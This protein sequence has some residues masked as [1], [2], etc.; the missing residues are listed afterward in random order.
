MPYATDNAVPDYVPKKHRAQ[1]RHV[2]NSTYDRAKEEGKDDKEAETLAFRE[3]NAV[4][5]PN[6]S[7]KFMKLLD[8]S[9][10]DFANAFADQVIHEIEKYWETLPVEV[11]PA[12]EGAILSGIGKGMLE[13]D[14]GDPQLLARAKDLAEQYATSRSAELVGWTRDANGNLIPNPDARWAI[15]TTTRERIREIIQNAFTEDL[16]I[17]EVRDQIQL[18]LATQIEGNGIFSMGRAAIIARTE[19][20]N[21]QS[22][23]NFVAWRESGMVQKIRWLTAEDE[24]VCDVCE[25]NDNSVV[26]IGQP[27]PTGDL[28]PG[29]HP[30]CRCAIV[31]E[32]SQMD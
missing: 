16:P 28:Y 10:T 22:Y 27:F 32:P 26:P 21:A 20:S 30:A 18:A 25:E 9:R 1:W 4:A 13:T 14:V 3:A 29:I 11:R 8:E 19:I 7:K 12:L 17:E 24:K 23:G 6:A 31:I 5:G 2:W 15:S